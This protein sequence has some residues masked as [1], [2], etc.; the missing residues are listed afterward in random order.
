VYCGCINMENHFNI[1]FQVL[2]ILDNYF[3]WQISLVTSHRSSNL[4]RDDVHALQFN[5]SSFYSLTFKVA[6]IMFPFGS[7]TRVTSNKHVV[8]CTSKCRRWNWMPSFISPS[9]W[10]TFN[11]SQ[12]VL[13]TASQSNTQRVQTAKHYHIYCAAHK[14]VMSER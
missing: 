3:V 8:H 5:V 10:W 6:G 12:Q 9:V 2:Q 14:D 7:Q 1:F 11:M 13:H 4:P